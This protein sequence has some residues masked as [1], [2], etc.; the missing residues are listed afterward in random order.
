MTDEELRALHRVVVVGTSCAGKSTC[1]RRLAEALNA[2][3]IELDLLHWGPHW[4][5]R[6][7]WP[8]NVA[9]AV[10][11]ERWVCDGNYSAARDLVWPRATATIWLDYSFPRVMSRALRRTVRRVVTREPVCN[12]N[13]ESFRLAFLS[14][15][16]ILWWV[17]TTHQRRRREYVKLLAERA[18]NGHRVW[19]FHKP[20]ELEQFLRRVE[21]CK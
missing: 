13:R 16:S 15:E 9:E 10:Q 4:T 6:H 12:G 1:A 2:P 18:A 21:S 20:A 17:I 7:D 14:R 19:A 3:H 11:A 8:G 5:P